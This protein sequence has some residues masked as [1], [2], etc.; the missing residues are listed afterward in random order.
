MELSTEVSEKS[1]IIFHDRSKKWI[2]SKQAEAIYS[3]SGSTQ[4]GVTIDGSFYTFSSISKILS[5]QDFYQQFP[6]E[7][8]EET[9]EW[10][11]EDHVSLSEQ[12]NRTPESLSGLL[13]GLKRYIDMELSK[14]NT[15]KNAISLYDEKLK[16]YKERIEERE[17]LNK[18]VNF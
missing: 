17:E 11:K 1:I 9:P 3:M 7:R 8:P 6:D 14:G 10:K 2:S 4:K 12:V 5:V 13:K 15:P 16:K 18:L